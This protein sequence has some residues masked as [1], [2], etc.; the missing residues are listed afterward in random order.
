[1]GLEPS[2]TLVGK[3]QRGR[4]DAVRELLAMPRDEANEVVLAQLCA[5]DERCTF[6][7]HAEGYLELVE[8][9]QTPLACWFEHVRN[10]PEDLDE[11]L[12]IYPLRLLACG[13]DRGISGCRD[14]LVSYVEHGALWRAALDEFLLEGRDLPDATWEA[15]YP[16]LDAVELSRFIEDTDAWHRR[17]EDHPAVAAAMQLWRDQRAYW[18]WSRENYGEAERSSRRWKIV[19]NGLREDPEAAASLLVD[20]LWDGA[21]FYRAKCVERVDL[22]L[23][24]VVERLRELTRSGHRGLGRMAQRRLDAAHGPSEDPTQGPQSV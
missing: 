8:Q 2:D 15:L 19:E 21:H 5:I 12:R 4:G 16:R 9:L 20:G 23:P 22:G 3:L 14:F 10:L 11:D 13:A 1:M 6:L 7:D 17:A 18:A 24:G